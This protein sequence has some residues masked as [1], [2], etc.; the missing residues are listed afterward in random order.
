MN[1]I[2][3]T[4]KPTSIC[5][6]VIML[7]MFAPIH[8]VLAAM[9]GTET[10][11]DS[12]RGRE[13]RDLIHTFM[14]REDVQA[15][16]KS[17]G[18]DPMEAK[19]RVDT[20]SDEEVIRIADQIDQLPEGGGAVELLLVIILVMLLVLIIFDLTGVTDVFPFIKSQR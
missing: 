10:V 12:Q 6:T 14:A 1:L 3:K 2:R 13:A 15:A 5:L 17:Q 18:I 7:L 20:L 8:S 11:V 9:I 16:L 19:A 4:L